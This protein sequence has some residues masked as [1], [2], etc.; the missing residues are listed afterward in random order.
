M[1]DVPLLIPAMMERAEKYFAKKEVV[2]RTASRIQT[3]TYGEIA[4]RTR[5][6]ASVLN[7]MGIDRGDKVGTIAW[8]HHRHLEAYFA[9]P[10]IGAVYIR[11][12]YGSPQSIFLIS[13]TTPKIKSFL[14]M[15]IWFLY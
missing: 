5:R 13:L 6:L 11:L 15:K 2:S 9:I 4:K 12:T 10:G 7:K 3:L 1:M 8:N 14:L